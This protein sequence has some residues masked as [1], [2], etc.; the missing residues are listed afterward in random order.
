MTR[1]SVCLHWTGRQP[2]HTGYQTPSACGYGLSR[3]TQ[4]LHLLLLG[5]AASFY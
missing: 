2:S 3:E 1:A 4:N 5:Q